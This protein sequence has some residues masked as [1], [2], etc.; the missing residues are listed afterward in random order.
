[1]TEAQ[2][3]LS[4]ANVAIA[5]LRTERDAER[6]A[7]ASAEQAEQR[8]S[9]QLRTRGEELAAANRALEERGREL[10]SARDKVNELRARLAPPNVNPSAAVVATVSGSGERQSGLVA[11]N[12]T[13]SEGS[14]R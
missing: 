2:A 11:D 5:S 7:R 9:D 4:G 10:A 8:V 6:V 3:A 12:S 13:A 1:L 14:A